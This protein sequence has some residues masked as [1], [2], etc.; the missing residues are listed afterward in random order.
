MFCFR[1]D[2][3]YKERFGS[4]KRYFT[5][6]SMGWKGFQDKFYEIDPKSRVTHVSLE[7]LLWEEENQPEDMEDWKEVF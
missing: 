3:V 2:E 1:M 5:E 6:G 7:D 4:I